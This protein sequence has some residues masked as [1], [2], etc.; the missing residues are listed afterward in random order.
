MQSVQSAKWSIFALIFIVAGCGAANSGQGA[1]CTP[2]PSVEPKDCKVSA[3]N[4]SGGVEGQVRLNIENEQHL[5]KLCKSHCTRADAIDIG[6]FDKI[7]NLKALSRLEEI[8]LL[9]INRTKNLKSLNGISENTDIGTLKLSFNQGLTTLDGMGKGTT[10][11]H[12]VKIA[13]NRHLDSLSGIGTHFDN[14]DRIDVRYN[15]LE[16][17]GLADEAT[18]ADDAEV[19]LTNEDD[20]DDLSGLKGLEKIRYLRLGSLDSLTSLQGVGSLTVTGGMRI[21][22]NSDLPICRIDQFIEKVGLT[23]ESV[24]RFAN[25]PPGNC[26]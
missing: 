10:I 15:D 17:F 1:V 3:I 24:S 9:S 23:N 7:E 14:V 6:G 16:R 2:D 13:D 20:V 19:R 11:E 12:R 26:E 22:N 5:Q 8:G 18:L 4:Y 21:A 25:G